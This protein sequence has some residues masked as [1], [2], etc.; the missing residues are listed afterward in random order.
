MDDL[1]AA[2]LSQPEAELTRPFG[3]DVM[4]FKVATKMFALVPDNTAPPSVSLKGDPLD[5]EALRQRYEAAT[6]GYHLNKKHWNTIVSDGEVPDQ[7]LKN[8]I[9]DSY[10]LVVAGLPKT[11]RLLL[12]GQVRAV[13]TPPS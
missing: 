5:N 8:L 6:G 13:D 4:V 2:C 10:D 9:E 1:V 11:K 3:D 7:E 12:Q